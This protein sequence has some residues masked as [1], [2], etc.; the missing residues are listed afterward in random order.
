MHTTLFVLLRDVKRILSGNK[1][2]SL[3]KRGW[4]V[5]TTINIFKIPKF[6]V[7]KIG[8]SKSSY[9][10]ERQSYGELAHFWS[11]TGLYLSCSVHFGPLAERGEEKSAKVEVA[12]I[13]YYK[14]FGGKEG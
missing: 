5:N 12:P 7:W 9:D 8:C 2:M 3:E 1:E 10:A 11:Q 6:K 4:S 13:N 14:L